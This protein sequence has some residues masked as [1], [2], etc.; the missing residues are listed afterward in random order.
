MASTTNDLS[1]VRSEILARVAAAAQSGDV[2]DV[3]RWS[4]AAQDCDA[5]VREQV[6]L[7]ERV[8]RFVASLEQPSQAPEAELYVTPPTSERVSARHEGALARI[9]WLAQLDKSGVRL[10]G[11]GKR[12][13][14]YA[15]HAVSVGFAN[16]LPGLPNKWF[17]GTADEPTD[18]VV[19]LCR[20]T[21]RK[22]HD[23][24]VP[25]ADLGA[26]WK[27]LARNNGQIKFN[28]RRD[29]SEFLLL[30]P[31]AQPLVVSQYVGRYGPLNGAA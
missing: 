18:V 23:I 22:V 30:I 5:L 11:H 4:Q 13:A 6:R 28:V 20:D 31:G 7:E 25:V 27:M 9:E 26:R 15:G 3:A 10:N 16:E 17:L 29:V 2:A 14:T 19:L 12:F 1:P 24:V 8:R 21:R